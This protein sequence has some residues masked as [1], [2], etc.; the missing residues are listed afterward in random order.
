MYDIVCMML[1]ALLHVYSLFFYYRI[2]CV[3][4]CV[5]TVLLSNVLADRWSVCYSQVMA[6]GHCGLYDPVQ[7]YIS[8]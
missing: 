6:T 3:C 4:M 1:V 8:L 5:V 2:E 7:L